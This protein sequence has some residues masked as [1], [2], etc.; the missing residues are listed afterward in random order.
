VLGRTLVSAFKCLTGRASPEALLSRGEVLEH[1]ARYQEALFHYEKATAQFPQYPPL[2]EAL[3]RTSLEVREFSRAR[4][5]FNQAIACGGGSARSYYLLGNALSGMGDDDAAYAAF[6]MAL[7]HDPA[8]ARA[9]NNLGILLLRRGAISEAAAC[10]R[11]A[12]DHD[13]TLAQAHANLGVILAENADFAGA[14]NQLRRAIQLREHS[15]QVRANLGLALREIGELDSAQSV[16]EDALRDA[17]QD[18]LALKNLA[19]V[20]QDRG[21]LASGIKLL[22]RCLLQH[23]DD[24]DAH[25]ARSL[26]LLAQG[27]DYYS[28]WQE[29]EYRL[30]SLAQPPYP[31]RFPRWSGQHL[32]HERVLVTGEQ[33]IGDEIMFAGCIDEVLSLAKNIDL[34]CAD[35]LVTLFQRS[36]PSVQVI[37]QSAAIAADAACWHYDYQ[38]PCG[39]LGLLCRRRRESF[40]VHAG[41]LRVDAA[42]RAQWRERLASLGPGLKIGIAWSGGTSR[43]RA[44][45]RSVPLA[46]WEQVLR[47]PHCRFV[48]L[49]YC[50][51]DGERQAVSKSLGVSI[52]NWG[53]TLD[54]DA[55]AALVASLDLVISVQTAV[56]HLA[57]ALNIPVWAL[58]P[59]CPEW[60]YGVEGTS[61]PWYPSV[62]LYRQRNRGQW[63]P[64]LDE[65]AQQLAAAA[66]KPK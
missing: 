33:G 6:S 15:I 38:I 56:V 62:M 30:Q 9:H 31:F 63:E 58:I 64:V 14:V 35:K 48:S 13:P 24:A 1:A 45:L 20:A 22:D 37:P 3:G 16:L 4:D 54:Y 11:R 7:A 52:E 57:G 51:S 25:Y 55:T 47:V 43:T 65:I 59:A 32:N 66:A 28:G 12:L 44:Q 39:S 26:L 23:P 50:P 19:L 61:M 5:A 27:Q 10:F 18:A 2:L 29:Y 41:Y 8:H 40:P 60:R 21:D 46:Q 17:P 36:F 42:Q 34:V 49:Q 53:E